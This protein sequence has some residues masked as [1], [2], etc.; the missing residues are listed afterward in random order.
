MAKQ[1]SK[2]IKEKEV[3]PKIKQKALTLDIIPIRDI[4]D[5]NY[6][7]TKDNKIID[8][9]QIKC[10]SITQASDYEIESQISQLAYF[11]RRYSNDLKIFAMCYPTN[12][13]VQ[14]KYLQ[15][16]VL[17]SANE[18]HVYFLQQKLYAL[19]F[20]EE[21]RT[22]KEFYIMLFADN[23][24]QLREQKELLFTKS[25]LSIVTIPIEKKNNLFFKINNMNSK[26]R[27]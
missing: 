5:E 21:N 19:E 3:K 26:I 7:I 15:Q 17:N 16:K 4:S 12:T 8:L 14:Q 10:K 27:I 2:N 6:Y 22:D 1:K 9:F 18:N 11:F 23:Q 25:S 20:L 24:K 13:T